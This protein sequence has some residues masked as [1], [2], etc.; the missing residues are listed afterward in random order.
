MRGGGSLAP[1]NADGTNVGGVTLSPVA[2]D[3]DSLRTIPLAQ[4]RTLCGG[5]YDWL[6]A[7]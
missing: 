3:D 6:E 4:W 5:S 1:G 7:G 2:E